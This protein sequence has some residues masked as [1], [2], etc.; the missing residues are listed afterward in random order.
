MKIT[1]NETQLGR[2][3]NLI[4]RLNDKLVENVV[5][6]PAAY[7]ILNEEFVKIAPTFGYSLY[8]LDI[9]F[10]RVIS[11]DYTIWAYAIGTSDKPGD[12]VSMY[13][14]DGA[15]DDIKNFMSEI[16]VADCDHCSLNRNRATTYI[17]E[18]RRR[19]LLG[20]V[21]S[22]CL[23]DYTGVSVQTVKGLNLFKDLIESIGD[24]EIQPELITDAVLAFAL[25]T[26]ETDGKLYKK[27]A[28]ITTV[29]DRLNNEEEDVPSVDVESFKAFVKNLPDSDYVS[30]V[31]ELLDK[32]TV[33][34]DEINLL[35][36][37]VCLSPKEYVDEYVGEIDDKVNDEEIKIEDIGDYPD[38]MRINGVDKKNRQVVWFKAHRRT[39]P[40]TTRFF[41]HSFLDDSPYRVGNTVVI[42]SARVKNHRTFN[43]NKQTQLTHVRVK[44]AM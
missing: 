29:R 34:D 13:V 17:V 26:Y 37:S 27:S 33:R 5:D 8:T 14:A 35:I 38:Y 20:Q 22:T 10:P 44:E 2:L 12:F 42:S 4:A 24:E 1:V 11:G 19:N 40:P 32:T 6:A 23:S 41:E 25:D 9:K 3:D 43:G 30:K 21:G 31:K 28:T 15:G 7:E 18:D 39:A 16:I 36:S